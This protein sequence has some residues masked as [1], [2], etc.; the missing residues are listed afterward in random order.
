MQSQDELRK[1]D[2]PLKNTDDAFVEVGKDG[3]PEIPVET[4]NDEAEKNIHGRIENTENPK[5]ENEDHS[6]D[7]SK[8]DQQEGTMNNG[9]LGGNLKQ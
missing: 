6:A 2:A 9:E 7:I 1:Q 5:F 4:S 3:E 8:V